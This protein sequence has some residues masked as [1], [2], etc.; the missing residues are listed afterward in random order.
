MLA[1]SYALNS[2]N[3]SSVLLATATISASSFTSNLANAHTVFANACALNSHSISSA[4]LTPPARARPHSLHIPS[5]R[6]SG[7][8]NDY[9]T[10]TLIL[11]ITPWTL[12]RARPLC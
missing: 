4:L 7:L 10:L 8:A 2:R 1:K 11:T 12:G 9:P 6:G 3:I 5:P